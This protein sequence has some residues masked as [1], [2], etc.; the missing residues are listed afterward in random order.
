MPRVSV[1]IPCYNEERTISRLLETLYQQTFPR[2]HLE[3]VIADGRSTDRT[4]EFIEAFR[5]AR[6][7]LRVQLIVNKGRTIPQAL[8]LAIRASQGEIIVRMDA[9]SIPAPDYVANC[10]A[11]LEAGKGENVGGV[12]HIQPGADTWIARAIAAAAAHPVGAGDAKYRHASTAAYVDTVP[13][14][15]F[16][17]SLVDEIGFFDETLLANEDYE[18]NTRIR[19]AGKRIW[20][21]P[22]IHAEYFA[23]PTL[24]ALFRQYWRYGY[25]KLQ[26]LRRYPASLR[27]RQAIP[28]LFVLSLIALPLAGLW[29][30]LLRGLFR[31]E[32]VLYGLVIL[33]AA[34]AT[35]WRQK[36]ILHVLG[37]PLA[38]MTIHLAWGAAFLVALVGRP[39]VSRH[40]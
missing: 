5:H 39:G 23:R 32:M 26:M 4:I 6:P 15:A 36:R 1:I 37:L 21:D 31:V 27:A 38:F 34:A 35:A 9:H 13:F 16:Y 19:Q 3:I 7:E 30:P 14:G 2:D 17:K 22:S 24:S 10:V 12:W 20:L 25:W 28:P 40:G 33:S 11:A 8:N 18:F 29:L